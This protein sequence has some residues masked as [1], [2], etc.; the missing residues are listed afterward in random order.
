MKK[1]PDAPAISPAAAKRLQLQA[2][3]V[4]RKRQLEGTWSGQIKAHEDYQDKPVEWIVEFLG[5]PEHTIRWSLN[6]EYAGHKWDGDVDPITR[7]LES[8]AKGDDVGVESATGTGK[9]FIGACI[10]FWFLACFE[11]SIVLTA[12]PREDQLLENI[13]KEVGRLFP[14]FKSHFPNA[15]LTTGKIRM[16]PDEEGRETWAATAF[17]CGVGANE[18]SA[19]KAQGFHAEHMLIITEETPGIHSAIMNAFQETRTDDHNL[20]LAFGN[21]DNRNDPLHRFCMDEWVDH[22]RI[23]ALDHP[24]IV[25]GRSIVPGAIGRKRLEK[26]TQRLGKDSRLYKSRVR[27]ISPAESENALINWDWCVSAAKKW[28]DPRY[29]QGAEALGVDVANSENGDKGAIARWQGA[30]LTEVEDFPCP[31]GNELGARVAKE[32]KAKKIDP[33]YVAVDVVGVGAGCWN[34]MKRLGVKA[35]Q[36]SS[37]TRAIPG[38]DEDTLWSEMDTEMDGTYVPKG[39]RVIEAERFDNQRSQAWWRMREDLRQGRIALPDDEELFQDLTTP[40]FK[41]PGG[42]IRVQTKDDIVKNLKRSPNKGDAAVYGNWVRRRRPIN[43]VSEDEMESD[44]N[45]E[46]GLEKLIDMNTKKQ[47]AQAKEFRKALR[48][49]GRRMVG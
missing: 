33:R 17:V 31:D 48:R 10:L 44:M 39:A 29:R 14:V 46:Y 19:T 25:T 34:E 1:T 35:R 24:N 32:V 45:R 36:F 8:L 4:Q 26:R 20:H 49:A 5:V 15:V 18:E 11:D 13:W 47:M 6:E 21:P 42:I 28:D 41:S 37:A 3:A 16:K 40:T 7:I 22:V 43:E 23:S 9:T 30:C 38:L 2:Q 27:G 12:A